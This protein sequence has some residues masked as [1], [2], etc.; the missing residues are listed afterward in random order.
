M[1][2]ARLEDYPDYKDTKF[3][4][5]VE[6]WEPVPVIPGRTFVPTVEGEMPVDEVD[7]FW[8]YSPER[9]V[10]RGYYPNMADWVYML[11]TF[12]M[13][14]K[15]EDDNLYITL[16]FSQ[17]QWDRMELARSKTREEAREAHLH[18][19]WEM[20]DNPEHHGFTAEQMELAI[21]TGRERP[22]SEYI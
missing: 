4:T 19:H 9:L 22:V 14:V 20:V 11:W 3:K 1:K 15:D 13:I 2:R 18:F 5:I 10:D 12:S 8:W 21:T 17:S 16:R 7:D 6:A